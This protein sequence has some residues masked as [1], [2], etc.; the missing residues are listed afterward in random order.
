MNGIGNVG[1]DA[2]VLY[3]DAK[4]TLVT[5]KQLKDEPL[6]GN[7][8]VLM[9]GKESCPYM[10]CDVIRVEDYRDGKEVEGSFR[11]VMYGKV[12]HHV[13]LSSHP[14]YVLGSGKCGLGFG[15]C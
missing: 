14:A 11:F 2:F 12:F 8:Y 5:L 13:R 6:I 4:T 7:I 15:V 3:T 10:G 1:I 9:N